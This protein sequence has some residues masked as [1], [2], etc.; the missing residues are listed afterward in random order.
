M[1][2]F[3]DTSPD[4]EALQ[5]ELF[6]QASPAR[7]F[8]LMSSFGSTLRQGCIKQLERHFDTPQQARLEWV[9]LPYGETIANCLHA[10]LNVSGSTMN[11]MRK[12]LETL[13]RYLRI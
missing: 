3:I 13:S 5:L 6:K 12:A 1:A 11:E 10:T 7:R 4:V 9:R 8:A 2:L